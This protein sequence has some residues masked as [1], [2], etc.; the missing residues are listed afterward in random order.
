MHDIKHEETLTFRNKVLVVVCLAITLISV[1]IFNDK[2]PA[3]R[4][5]LSDFLFLSSLTLISINI[6]WKKN[7]PF[8]KKREY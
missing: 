8:R 5:E 4:T 2:F 6:Y 7:N 1:K 3:L